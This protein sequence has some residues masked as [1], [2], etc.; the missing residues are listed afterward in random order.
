[1]KKATFFSVGI[2]LAALLLTACA[3]QVAAP[4]V[5]YPDLTDLDK[6]SDVTSG[7]YRYID[8][9][10]GVALY[11]ADTYRLASA[12]TVAAV[13]ISSAIVT[14]KSG[15]TQLAEHP[16]IFRIV[17]TTLGTVTYVV[18]TYRLATAPSIAAV[19]LDTN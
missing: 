3:S 2:L 12:P 5:E 13:R 19:K 15:V 8:N 18:D 16:A 14:P 6:V 10:Y 9:D 17:D 11:I 1:M 4:A 7:I